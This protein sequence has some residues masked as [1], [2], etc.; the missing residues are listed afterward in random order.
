MWAHPFFSASHGGTNRR[1]LLYNLRG[2][3]SMI[4]QAPSVMLCVIMITRARE[5]SFAILPSGQG[6]SHC[7]QRT[8][9]FSFHRIYNAAAFFDLH[10]VTPQ[11]LCATRMQTELYHF[12]PYLFLDGIHDRILRAQVAKLVS[13]FI[14]DFCVAIATFTLESERR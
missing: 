2:S 14:I 9:P 10:F 7:T 11:D 4:S 3:A 5:T 6:T 1:L 13:V 8:Y 12:S